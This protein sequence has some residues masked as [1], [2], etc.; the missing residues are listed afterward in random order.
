MSVSNILFYFQEL[1]EGSI[2]NHNFEFGLGGERIEK[3]KGELS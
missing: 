3:L 1:F 2:K